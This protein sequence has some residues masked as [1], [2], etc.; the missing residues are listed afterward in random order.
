MGRTGDQDVTI[1]D[2][3]VSGSHAMI[4]VVELPGGGGKRLTLKVGE[5]L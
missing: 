4:D 1:S 2:P 3:S 5:R